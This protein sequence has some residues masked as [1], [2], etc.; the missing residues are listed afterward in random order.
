MTG[1]CTDVRRRRGSDPDPRRS[2]RRVGRKRKKYFGP[3]TGREE[4]ETST[5]KEEMILRPPLLTR[6][7]AERKSGLI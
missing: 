5:R 7:V 4:E 2:V 3:D 1:Y 6:R